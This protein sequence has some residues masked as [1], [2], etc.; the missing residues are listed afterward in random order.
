M[1]THSLITVFN[2]RSAQLIPFRDKQQ[3]YFNKFKVIICIYSK[4]SMYKKNRPVTFTQL[5]FDFQI[6]RV[7]LTSQASPENELIFTTDFLELISKH[8]DHLLKKGKGCV[9]G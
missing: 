9:E 1:S 5:K 2:T 8:R 3:R 6:P 7:Y 4:N